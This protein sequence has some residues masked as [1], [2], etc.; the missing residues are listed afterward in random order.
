MKLYF[1][2]DFMLWQ[3]IFNNRD[4]FCLTMI[5]CLG[6]PCLLWMKYAKSVKFSVEK[7]SL[8]L[9]LGNFESSSFLFVSFR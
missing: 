7:V 4:L 6:S 8:I 2:L 1:P 5:G 9:S 3:V